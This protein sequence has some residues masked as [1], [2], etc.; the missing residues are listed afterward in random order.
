MQNHVIV[1]IWRE[2][3]DISV[4]FDGICEIQAKIRP[5]ASELLAKECPFQRKAEIV[6]H[7]IPLCNSLFSL[8]EEL[9][10]D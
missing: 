5:L 1:S 6:E 4:H 9:D 10:L 3:T 7:I 2:L 8:Q